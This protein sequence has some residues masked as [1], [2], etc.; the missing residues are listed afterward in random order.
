MPAPSLVFIVGPSDEAYVRELASIFLDRGGCAVYVEL[1]A[2][3]EER[4]RRNETE[5]R[6]AQKPTE[7]DLPESR[8]R[9]LEDDARYRLDSGGAF[10]SRADYLRIDNTALEPAVVAERVIDHFGLP[11]ATAP[12]P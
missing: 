4:L 11:R 9:L 6:L 10:D 8:R 7:S 5:F 12:P 2:T 3:L 1:E